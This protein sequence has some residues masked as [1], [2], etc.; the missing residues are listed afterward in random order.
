MGNKKEMKR[1]QDW[2][3]MVSNNLGAT[4]IKLI[5]YSTCNLESK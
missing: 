4:V 1:D 3:S 5:N 2:N